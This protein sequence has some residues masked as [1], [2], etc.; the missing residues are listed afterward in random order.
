M[1][2][3]RFTF[4]M[5]QT[6]GHVTF[7]QNL[8]RAF[9]SEPK[10]K[11]D[12]LPIEYKVQKRW[13]T[14]PLL[15]SN[16]SLRGSL[17]A[18]RAINAAQKEVGLSDL[19]FIHTQVIGLLT[20]GLL[21]SAASVI[22]SL[23]A[24]PINYDEVGAAYGHTTTPNSPIEKFKFWLNQRAFQHATRIVA[25]TDWTRQSLIK[26]YGI[27][28]EK[29]EVIPAGTNLDFWHQ[30]NRD[31]Q[32]V[33]KPKV[34]FVG[35]DFERKGGQLLYT[36]FRSQ[37]SDKAELHLV[38]KSA[39]TDIEGNGVFVHRNISP[40]SP[41]LQSLYQQADLFVLPTYGD[42]I[43]HSILEAMAAGLPIVSTT[44][45]AISE[46]VTEGQNGLLI[47]PGDGT[48]LTQT[49]AQL[50]DNANLRQQM[51][52]QNRALAEVKYDAA[53]NSQRLL[54]LCKAV[55]HVG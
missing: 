22:L 39:P 4:V 42:C 36:A 52:V 35:G 53:A 31:A 26:D 9:A 25:W 29:I 44:V 49:L 30:P 24:T 12:W 37:F 8:Q 2:S 27:A 16:W 21:N 5:E 46:M 54:D 10:V 3:K 40:N 6:L 18:R 50:I 34:L 19:Y 33:V 17:K 41:E 23:D 45:G 47:K 7:S 51:S 28:S 32:T 55:A 43:P 38:T 48:A 15:K 14:L 11:I 1:A 20:A 13:E